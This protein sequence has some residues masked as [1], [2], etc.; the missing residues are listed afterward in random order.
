LPLLVG[1]LQRTGRLERIVNVAHFHDMGKLMFAFVVFWAYIAFS[2]YMLI[3]YGNLPEETVWYELRQS[4]PWLWL[5]LLLLFGHFIVPFL[6]LMSRH[7][8]RRRMVLFG[9]ALWLLA[10]HW[11]D[12]FY[13]VVPNGRPAG[14][15]LRLADLTCLL[16]VGGIFLAGLFWRLGSARLVAVQDPRLSESLGLENV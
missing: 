7:T 4:G 5:S 14:P 6:L 8:K 10:M 9:A 1:L 15:P 2:Q 13:L 12:L 3:W 16:G 11:F